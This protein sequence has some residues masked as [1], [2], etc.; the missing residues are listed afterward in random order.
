M[1]A[2]GPMAGS[3]G[4]QFCRGHLPTCPLPWDTIEPEEGAAQLPGQASCRLSH[5]T[6]GHQAG[7]RTAPSD[8]RGLR[9]STGRGWDLGTSYTWP[10]SQ[11]KVPQGGAGRTHKPASPRCGEN[12]PPAC[13]LA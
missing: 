11:A 8:S 3:R 12:G 6:S 7:T 5:L 1:L 10:C 4:Y 2:P 13:S 9:S